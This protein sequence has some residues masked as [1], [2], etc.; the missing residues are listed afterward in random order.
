MSESEIFSSDAD[1]STDLAT[2]G[3]TGTSFNTLSESYSFIGIDMWEIREVHYITAK[4]GVS[5]K[6]S[7]LRIGN[8]N[9]TFGNDICTKVKKNNVVKVRT[10]YCDD[11]SMYGRYVFMHR[12]TPEVIRNLKLYKLEIYCL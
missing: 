8:I 12:A 10:Y 7:Y 1:T 6:G 9:Y 4:I 3:N 2:D 11:G 5:Q